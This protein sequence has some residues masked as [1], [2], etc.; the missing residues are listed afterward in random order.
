MKKFPLPRFI[1]VYLL[2]ALASTGC[3][4]SADN[5]PETRIKLKRDQKN[6]SAFFDNSENFV[7][8]IELEDQSKDVYPAEKSSGPST[9]EKNFRVGG[10]TDPDCLSLNNLKDVTFPYWE[11]QSKF[12]VTSILKTCDLS[13]GQK[14]YK[15]G[16][17]VV[18]MGV[19]CSG[20]PTKPKIT[21]KSWRPAVVEFPF[22]NECPM[23]IS[24]QVAGLRVK[25]I[26]GR[27]DFKV[28]ALNP[29]A[30]IYWEMVDYPVAGP[31]FTVTIGSKKL[32]NDVWKPLEGGKPL[33]VRL[34]IK[35]SSW[36][37]TEARY[38]VFGQIN[39]SRSKGFSLAVSKVESFE[40]E[41]WKALVA[42][43]AKTRSKSKCQVSD[44]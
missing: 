3:V 31:G 7:E 44:S 20:D 9:S 24:R 22:S 25:E 1:P 28:A 13:S 34:V 2:F 32:I 36:F 30:V 29:A 23:N 41:G 21:G 17:A 5:N 27:D 42:K 16:S 6:D 10:S 40:S 18:T 12:F 43:C 4:T 19:P 15:N 33:A 37:K 11:P 35:E 26:F 8:I 38:S 14:G 39:Y